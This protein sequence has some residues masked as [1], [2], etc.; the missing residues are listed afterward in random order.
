[1]VHCCFSTNK[2]TCNSCHGALLALVWLICVIQCIDSGPFPKPILAT[3]L[4]AGSWSPARRKLKSALGW[5]WS[6]QCFGLLSAF[7]ETMFHLN[8]FVLFVFSSLNMN[9]SFHLWKCMKCAGIRLF[10]CTAGS[11]SASDLQ[12]GSIRA[13]QAGQAAVTWF[14]F[15]FHSWSWLYRCKSYVCKFVCCQ[16]CCSR[17]VIDFVAFD[18]LLI[19]LQWSDWLCQLSLD[20]WTTDQHAL[21]LAE[22]DR[23]ERGHVF[24][25]YTRK[26]FRW[27]PKVLIFGL[28]GSSV[29]WFNRRQYE[30]WN[31]VVTHHN[32][33][34]KLPVEYLGR[35]N[36]FVFNGCFF[37][38][39]FELWVW[40][41]LQAT[42][43]LSFIIWG[44]PKAKGHKARWAEA[45]AFCHKSSVV[46][47]NC[48]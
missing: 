33:N 12:T 35:C 36:E 18:V 11:M 37:A 13:E 42:T 43:S 14:K 41:S 44:K 25:P 27:P 45:V 30:D 22:V 31:Y 3:V 15:M 21:L 2:V 40:L 39:A 10:C 26:V 47:P 1:M 19:Q 8:M 48:K 28:K 4:V 34:I 38:S 9:D 29:G 5:S 16:C 24:C 20:M 32:L 23:G 17:C 46:C 7:V 6:A